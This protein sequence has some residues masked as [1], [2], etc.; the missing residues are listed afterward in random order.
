MTPPSLGV[1]SLTPYRLNK[2][3]APNKNIA[4]D[5]TRTTTIITC[6]IFVLSMLLKLKAAPEIKKTQT[7]KRKSP[8]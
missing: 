2:K 4:I 7:Q 3:I 5:N 6:I 8:K 1:K